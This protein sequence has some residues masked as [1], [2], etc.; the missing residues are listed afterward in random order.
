M[1]PLSAGCRLY[2]HPMDILAYLGPFS[3][4]FT[5]QHPFSCW[6][7][8]TP[9]VAPLA[10]WGLILSFLHPGGSLLLPPV[11]CLHM[12]CCAAGDAS[13]FFS[14]PL[15]FLFPL[16]LYISP[17]FTFLSSVLCFFPTPLCP[18][19]AGLVSPR[20]DLPT[21]KMAPGRN[22]AL[23]ADIITLPSRAQPR[24]LPDHRYMRLLCGL[25]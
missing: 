7:N 19:L 8:P 13:L 4:L 21:P 9:R 17:S 12:L 3:P 18:V 24:L 20:C 22:V 25:P 2:G 10:L 14:S 15:L 5:P 11:L 1:Y 16:P 23:C 6:L